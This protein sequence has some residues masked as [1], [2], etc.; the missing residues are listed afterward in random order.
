MEAQK[1]LLEP[2]VKLF[3]FGEAKVLKKAFGFLRRLF[4]AIPTNDS[5]IWSRPRHPR[6]AGCRQDRSR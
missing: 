6:L 2:V 3:P 5:V 1:D 4:N